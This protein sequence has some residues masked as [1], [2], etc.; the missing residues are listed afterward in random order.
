MR[1]F[2]PAADFIT[3]FTL[4]GNCA[5]CPRFVARSAVQAAEPALLHA[6]RQK[7]SVRSHA[8]CCSSAASI[9]CA[10]V[11]CTDS[12]SRRTACMWLCDLDDY[13]ANKPESLNLACVI[14]RRSMRVCGVFV[15]CR[16]HLQFAARQPENNLNPAALAPCV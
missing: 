9:V 2:A 11:G 14:V 1:R 5:H 16:L 15:D 10:V 7:V 13:N 3:A 12:A 4:A 6:P 8:V